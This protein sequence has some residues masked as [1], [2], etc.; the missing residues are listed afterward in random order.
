M[1]EDQKSRVLELHHALNGS[2]TI[3]RTIGEDVEDVRRVLIEAGIKRPA[4]RT[5]ASMT[6]SDLSDPNR[7]DRALRRF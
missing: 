6:G 5:K 7:A 2:L 3:A 1:T 4:N